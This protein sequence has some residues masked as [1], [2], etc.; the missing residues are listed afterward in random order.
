MIKVV[1]FLY[2]CYIR[3][4]HIFFSPKRTQFRYLN[5]TATRIGKVGEKSEPKIITI[6]INLRLGSFDNDEGFFSFFSS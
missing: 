5:I 1:F 4:Q 3:Y 2:F 6:I